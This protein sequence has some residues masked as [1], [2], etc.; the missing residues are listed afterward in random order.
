LIPRTE[1]D[2]GVQRLPPASDP[3]HIVIVH[4]DDGL[5]RRRRGEGSGDATGSY[6][7][8]HLEPP[9]DLLLQAP[10]FL[11]VAALEQRAH[12]VGA[13]LDGPLPQ[14]GCAGHAHLEKVTKRREVYVVLSGTEL[15]MIAPVPITLGLEHATL[16][17][18]PGGGAGWAGL[19][20]SYRA[21]GGAG[22]VT[23]VGEPADAVTL[24]ANFQGEA[25]ERQ[26]VDLAGD[27][28]V[29]NQMRLEPVPVERQHVLVQSHH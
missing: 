29:A 23:I 13:L 27:A 17:W 5:P 8:G 14:S 15:W 22:A 9:G 12:R 11:A 24:P 4:V 16:H 1:H 3:M 6:I 28:V 2:L 20:P 25:M 26:F 19:E 7:L 18:Y 10:G 21:R